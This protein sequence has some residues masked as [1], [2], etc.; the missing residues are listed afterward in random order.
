MSG[1]PSGVT[2][3]TTQIDGRAAGTAVNAFTSVSMSPSLL[4]VCLAHD[5]RTLADIRSSGVFGVNI[6]AQHHADLAM[7]CAS[8]AEKDRFADVVLTSAVTGAPLLGDAVAWFD[9]EVESVVA[10]GDHAIV[11]GRAL[12]AHAAEDVSP[13]LYH[14]GRLAPLQ[15]IDG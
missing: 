10:A 13:L 3:V 9:C 6:L 8:K 7:R 4:L 2:V 15:P 14:L 1:F 12:A 5:S 11:T